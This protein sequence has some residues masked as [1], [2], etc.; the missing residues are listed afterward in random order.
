M[1]VDG[2]RISSDYY[3]YIFTFLQIKIFLLP[4]CSYLS[5]SKLLL[6]QQLRTYYL[7]L[8]F[9]MAGIYFMFQFWGKLGLSFINILLMHFLLDVSQLW[10][11]TLFDSMSAKIFNQ[12]QERDEDTCE[13]SMIANR[14]NLRDILLTVYGIKHMGVV[15]GWGFYYLISRL[16]PDFQF[17]FV[18]LMIILQFILV[19]FMQDMK[20][21]EQ[22]LQTF[23]ET[24]SGFWQVL[25]D[26][27]VLGLS[28]GLFVCLSAPAFFYLFDYYL[29]NI[30][31]FQEIDFIIKNLSSDIAYLLAL[32]L[33]SI[34]IS[35]FY[36]SQIQ[37]GVFLIYLVF[38][39][40]LIYILR[41]D[42]LQTIN[43]DKNIL[44]SIFYAFLYSLFY[45]SKY[46]YMQILWKICPEGNQ[47][48]FMGMFRFLIDFCLFLGMVFGSVF[49]AVSWLQENNNQMF[50]LLIIGH[51]VFIIIGILILL[52]NIKKI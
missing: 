10:R 27:G 5:Q 46:P 25:K 29:K 15:V 42:I 32:I 8:T 22:S 4:F 26:F 36:L 45:V 50:S 28:F 39:S 3:Q 35:R 11:L 7:A 16:L 34:L 6:G 38:I 41:V 33:I 51:L 13:Q 23:S 37:L 20:N 48:F 43:S 14:S 40:F 12:V 24:L 9:A 49:S 44:L 1:Y 18:L 19:Y 30:A 31:N 52:T 17:G 47:Q 21:Q 2:Y